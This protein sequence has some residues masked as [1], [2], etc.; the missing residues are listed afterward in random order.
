[1]KVLLVEDD[2]T[3]RLLFQQALTVRGHEVEACQD[4]ESAWEA[5]QR[6][7]FGLVILDWILPGQDGL[8]FCRRIR[9]LP[10]GDRAV[11]LMNTV[12]DR[13]QDLAAAL[14]AGATDYLTKPIDASLLEVRL[15]IAERTV[16]DRLKRHQIEAELREREERYRLLT[17]HTYDLIC[18]VSDGGQFLYASPNYREVLGYEPESLLGQSIFA[19]VHPADVPAVLNEFERAMRTLSV[20]KAIFRFLHADGEWRWFESTGNVFRTAD[21]ETHGVIVSRDITERRRID[22]E[23]LRASKLESVGLLAGGIAHDFNNVLTAI[24]GNVSLAKLSLPMEGKVS[25]HLLDVE[26]ACLRAKDLTQRLLTFAKGGA[27]VKKGTAL[28]DLVRESTRFALSGSNVRCEYVLPE[29]LWPV[30]VD[31][32]QMS[33]VLHNLVI[34]AHQAMPTGGCLTI[35]V[36]NVEVGPRDGA[37]SLPLCP[38]PYLMLRLTDEGIGIAPEH[39]SKVFDPYFTTKQEGSGLGLATAYSVVRNHEGYMT[40]ESELGKG[41]TFY[42]YLPASPGLSLAKSPPPST[43]WT[44]QGRILVMDDEELIRRLLDQTLRQLGYEVECVR[45]G[46]EAIERYRHAQVSGRPFDVVLMDLTIPGGMGGQEAVRRLHTLDPAV[47]AVVLS[48]Y[49]NDPVMAD[50]RRY[51]FS[52]QLAKPYTVQQLSET[53]HLV[54]GA[55]TGQSP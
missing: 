43:A 22:E 11:I 16:A 45:D 49:S 27:P 51:G 42:L 35:A 2:G 37:G 44:G 19:K 41:T 8:T 6:Q 47:K 26:K 30:E 46:T 17:E 25:S 52:E 39:L 53:L 32:G 1:M 50:Y 40:V 3:T 15:T 33:Q 29:G 13:S 12:R 23:R 54:L 18:E 20:G 9:S 5:C 14:D 34:N 7:A 10:W 4:A 38:G 21:S 24:L 55:T 28:A 48:G 31:E 36:E